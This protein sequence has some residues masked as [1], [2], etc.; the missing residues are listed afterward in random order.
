MSAFTYLESAE[1]CYTAFM[2]FKSRTEAGIA[3][4]EKLLPKYS[5]Q[6]CAVVALSDG[7]V[8][9]ASQIA[10]RLRSAL[11]LLLAESID[12]PREPESIASVTQDGGF[13]YNKAYSPSELEDLEGEYRTYIDQERMFKT[14]HINELLGEG[15]LIRKSLLVKRNVILVS[16]GLNSGFSLDAASEFLKPLAIKKLII[17]TPLASVSAVD[18]MHVLAD[19]I[20]C[21]SVIED[22]LSTEHYYEVNDVPDHQVIVEIV[23]NVLEH[24]PATKTGTI[25]K[26]NP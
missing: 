2:Y 24:W 21:L 6:R 10:L 23:E 19:E 13:A 1:E 25:L 18:R 16:D 22:Y 7:G 9:V 14:H 4:S 5:N 12:L 8:L 26:D 11:M 20:F 17:A 3:L 15:N